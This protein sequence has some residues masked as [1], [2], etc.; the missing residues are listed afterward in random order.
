[1][2]HIDHLK[3]ALERAWKM[4]LRLPLPNQ[5]FVILA[6]AS[7]YSAGYVLMMEDY[8]TFT[9]D[10]AKILDGLGGPSPLG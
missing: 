1:M 5:Q 9:G 4:S 2:Q 7:Y 8:T 3:G 10:D 6:D